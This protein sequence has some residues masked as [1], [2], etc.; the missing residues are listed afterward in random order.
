MG[1]SLHTQNIQTNKVIGENEKRAFHFTE[2]KTNEL[3]GQPNIT[4]Q[5]K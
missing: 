1:D 4:Q 2:K 3:F 5:L